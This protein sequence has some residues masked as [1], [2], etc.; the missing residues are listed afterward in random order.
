MFRQSLRFAALAAA[1]ILSVGCRTPTS[2]SLV[3]AAPLPPATFP[4]VVK[5]A[6]IFVFSASPGYP[7]SGYTSESR[8]VLYDDGAFALQY[9]RSLGSPLYPGTYKEAD[10]KIT[11][12]FDGGGW[13]DPGQADARGVLEGDSLTVS[14]NSRMQFSDFE[15][16]VYVRVR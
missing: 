6:R 14:Y 2:P 15:D 12:T 1:L 5:P 11:F 13:S 3:T 16:G 7:V 4:D 10:G 8:Y 9:L